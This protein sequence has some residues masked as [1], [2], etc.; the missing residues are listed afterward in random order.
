MSAKQLLIFG[1]FVALW[2]AWFMPFILKRRGGGNK[3]EVRASASRWGMLLQAVA[4]GLGSFHYAAWD[5]FTTTR[6]VASLI[7]EA[8]AVVLAWTSVSALG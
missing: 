6:A 5:T 3:P 7:F 4:F 8:I 2:I 1:T